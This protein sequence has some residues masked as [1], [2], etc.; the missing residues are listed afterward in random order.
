MQR[1]SI[2]SAPFCSTRD[3]RRMLTD[4]KQPPAA[5]RGT[6]ARPAAGARIAAGHSG[7]HLHAL[8]LRPGTRWWLRGGATG[9]DDLLRESSPLITHREPHEERGPDA[10]RSGT[11]RPRRR[12]KAACRTASRRSCG[13]LPV[14]WRRRRASPIFAAAQLSRRASLSAARG[15]HRASCCPMLDMWKT[16][17]PLFFTRHGFENF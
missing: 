10:N 15:V 14:L 17:S 3:L 13:R 8:L 16:R 9:G 1:L 7:A 6:R 12:L 2:E 4:A 5:P 11:D